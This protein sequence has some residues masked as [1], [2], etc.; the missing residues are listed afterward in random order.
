MNINSFQDFLSARYPVLTGLKGAI[1]EASGAIIDCYLN[2]GKILVCGNGGSSSD[3]DHMVGE[4]MKRF[5]L[6]RP[7]Q[8]DIKKKLTGVAGQRSKY[9]TRNLES[10]LPAI[11]LSAHTALTSAIANDMGA[12]LVFAQQV[13][14]Y[15]TGNDLLLA[16]SSSGNSQNVVDACI[17][18]RAIGLKVIGVTG[19]KGGKMKQF[20]D[21]LINVPEK[22]T[23]LVQELHLPVLHTLCLIVENYF[24]G[25]PNI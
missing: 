11:S 24:Y 17:T 22:R 5:E 1:E 9:L 19:I 2:G 13:I 23:A 18:A 6:E 12:S 10:G 15:G 16:I 3:A 8:E 25:H 4:L 21:I 20:C 7:L 14:V